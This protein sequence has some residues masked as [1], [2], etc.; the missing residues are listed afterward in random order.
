MLPQVLKW[1]GVMLLHFEQATS[2]TKVVGGRTQNR[3]PLTE[4]LHSV[5]GPTQDRTIVGTGSRDACA[6]GRQHAR[7]FISI[8]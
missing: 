6:T 2:L 8:S 7:G 4:L 3:L 1:E 5:A